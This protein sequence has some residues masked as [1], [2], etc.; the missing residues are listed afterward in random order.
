MLWKQEIRNYRDPGNYFVET[1]QVI[2]VYLEIFWTLESWD[3]ICDEHCTLTLQ[4]LQ[5]RQPKI[6]YIV[7]YAANWFSH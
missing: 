6:N 2:Y 5:A 1:L 7:I 3:N 4:E